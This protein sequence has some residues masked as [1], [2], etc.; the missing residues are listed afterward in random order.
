MPEWFSYTEIEDWIVMKETGRKLNSGFSLGEMMAV[1]AIMAILAAFATVGVIQYQRNLTLLEYDNTAEEIFLAAQNR[2]SLLSTKDLL[3]GRDKS[4]YGIDVGEGSYVAIYNGTDKSYTGAVLADILPTG[5]IEETARVSGSYMVKYN[6]NESVVEDVFFSNS[7][8]SRFGY[9]FSRSDIASTGDGY[10]PAIRAALPSSSNDGAEVRKNFTD[11]KKII[12]FYGGSDA[13][14]EAAK[15]MKPKIVI[16]NGDRLVLHIEVPFEGGK[17]PERKD[18]MLSVQG[19]ESGQVVSKKLSEMGDSV[20]NVASADPNLVKFDVV[21]DDVTVANHR[22]AAQFAALTH[23]EDINVVVSNS[24]GTSPA[25]SETARDNSLYAGIIAGSGDGGIAITSFRH[26]LNMNPKMSEVKDHEGVRE[27]FTEVRQLNDLIWSDFLS[28]VGKSDADNIYSSAFS[29]DSDLIYSAEKISDPEIPGTSEAYSIVGL[30][31]TADNVDFGLFGKAPKDHVFK[32]SDLRLEGCSF[33]SK[34]QSTGAV[35]GEFQG[36]DLEFHNIYVGD[37]VDPDTKDIMESVFL[38]KKYAGGLV[39]SIAGI[40]SH[41]KITQCESNAYIMGEETAGGLIGRVDKG[42]L[43][44]SNTYVAGHTRNAYYGLEEDG[45][46]QGRINIFAGSKDDHKGSAGGFVGSFKGQKDT[47]SINNCYTTA[48]IAGNKG[49]TG[50]YIGS[51]EGNASSN[52]TTFTIT[53]VYSLGPVLT[54]EL[55]PQTKD[56]GSKSDFTVTVTEKTPIKTA[57]D[58][59]VVDSAYPNDAALKIAG[60]D[61]AAYPYMTILELAGENRADMTKKYP[62]FLR[63]HYG[64][65][66]TAHPTE[67]KLMNTN[68]LTM[69]FTLPDDQNLFTILATGVSSGQANEECHVFSYDRAQKKLYR[70]GE[71]YKYFTADDASGHTVLNLYMDDISVEGGHFADLFPQLTPGEDVTI[72]LSTGMISKSLMDE[73]TDS[74]PTDLDGTEKDGVGT[75]NSLF[76]SVNVPNRT[77]GIKNARHLQNMDPS[78]SRVG[79]FG[80]AVID[81]TGLD[82]IHPTNAIQAADIRWYSYNPDDKASFVYDVSQ[83]NQRE[84]GSQDVITYAARTYDE[85]SKAWTA[86]KQLTNLGAGHTNTFYGISTGLLN[87]YS[88]KRTD[89]GASNPNNRNAYILENFIIDATNA[90]NRDDSWDPN[91]AIFKTVS[92]DLTIS[93]VYLANISAYATNQQGSKDGGAAAALVACIWDPTSQSWNPK[94]KTLTLKG[95]ITLDQSA[96][97]LLDDDRKQILGSAA[98]GGLIGRVGSPYRTDNYFALADGTLVLKENCNVRIN[99]HMLVNSVGDSRN[100]GYYGQDAGGFVGLVNGNL[101]I[102][103][104]S[105]IIMNISGGKTSIVANVEHAGGLAGAVVGTVSMNMD[106]ATGYANFISAVGDGSLE[107][108]AGSVDGVT[109]GGLFGKIDNYSNTS[110]NITRSAV[111]GDITVSSNANAGV[112]GGLIGQIRGNMNTHAGWGGTYY[113][114]IRLCFASVRTVQSQAHAGG[115]IGYAWNGININNCYSSGRNDASGDSYTIHSRVAGGLLGHGEDIIALDSF[116]TCTVQ[117]PDEAS[118]CEGGFVGYAAYSYIRNCYT[119]GR[120]KTL[121][122]AYINAGTFAGALSDTPIV[123]ASDYYTQKDSP[124]GGVGNFDSSVISVQSAEENRYPYV[125]TPD[126]LDYHYDASLTTGYPLRTV[127]HYTDVYNILGAGDDVTYTF[128]GDWPN[129]NGVNNRRRM[130]MLAEDGETDPVSDEV[131]SPNGQKAAENHGNQGENP[132]DP[133]SPSDPALPVTRKVYLYQFSEGGQVYAVEVGTDGTISVY[134]VITTR[135]ESGQPIQVLGDA[136]VLTAGEGGM[137]FTTEDASPVSIRISTS[138]EGKTLAPV[139]NNGGEDVAASSTASYEADAAE[140]KLSNTP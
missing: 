42:S 57:L 16:E 41:T 17:R 110:V 69:Q 90:V 30:K 120:I 18:L 114:N 140:K 73:M 66:E 46:T 29:P 82:V 103:D 97:S 84:I 112:A 4:A 126:G 23:G 14:K 87:S 33:E 137:C 135:D 133:T 44:I 124:H 72:R 32:V 51:L 5:S 49:L 107:V 58:A 63:S 7:A 21:L 131:E 15:G 115:L 62:V 40:G 127:C 9:V 95:N 34:G 56:V 119:A 76:D 68:K 59:S 71:E 88:A 106:D 100:A 50:K 108:T 136:V 116:S 10:S 54:Q 89:T 104:S 11:E 102:E 70:D 24:S 19:V 113:S 8:D 139:A 67:F 98:A 85:G 96:P 36:S 47:V 123:N 22:F 138:G 132:V 111:F 39:G 86:G 101:S 60:T 99:G 93:D 20:S 81:K 3:N 117:S 45:S 78:V 48:S 128:I 2:L 118:V 77:I 122:A 13:E 26:F 75:V 121:S 125:T 65:W 109:A 129:P 79:Q 43:D 6:P 83:I 134:K 1:V 25:T 38:A 61:T 35:L 74:I 130:A 94:P 52:N 12:G 27:K 53:N 37:Y 80:Y 92:S 31:G 64:D 55:V 105:N 91:A 28:N